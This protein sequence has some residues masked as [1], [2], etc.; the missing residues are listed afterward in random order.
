MQI[1]HYRNEDGS[2]TQIGPEH[3]DYAQ[4]LA[5]YRRSHP[6]PPP[7]RLKV[8]LMGLAMVA[9][10]VAAFWW[11][12][13][14]LRDDHK[15]SVKLY[16][17]AGMCLAFGLAALIASVLPARFQEPRTPG[18]L[19]NREQTLIVGGVAGVMVIGLLA[20]YLIHHWMLGQLGLE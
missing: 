5:E 15:Y 14:S 12:W 17:L 2:V 11:Q 6:A 9:G 20:A 4:L 19:S 18:P 1:L 3:P 13:V 8:A 10:G 7:E 16:L